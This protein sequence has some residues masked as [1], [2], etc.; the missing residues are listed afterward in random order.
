MLALR[1]ATLVAVA[2][3][4]VSAPAL[5]EAPSPAPAYSLVIARAQIRTRSPFPLDCDGVCVDSAYGATFDHPRTLSGPVIEGPLHALVISHM[6][7]PDVPMLLVV[8]TMP[9]RSPEVVA[10]SR[11]GSSRAN[12]RCIEAAAFARLGWNPAGPGIE[13][14]GD[15]V[16]ADVSEISK[17]PSSLSE[18]VPIQVLS[19]RELRRSLRRQKH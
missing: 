14:E 9:D 5:A 7:E 4:T 10:W 18:A 8:Q 11:G 2:S 15:A 3:A 13:M 17:L 16:C 1:L 19:P 12:F 6:R